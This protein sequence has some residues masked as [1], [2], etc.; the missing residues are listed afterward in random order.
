[1]TPFEWCVIEPMYPSKPKVQAVIEINDVICCSV[2]PWREQSCAGRQWGG[3]IV[4]G[5]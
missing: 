4:M 3:W 2:L 1:M 5:L